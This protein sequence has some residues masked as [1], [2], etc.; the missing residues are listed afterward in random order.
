MSLLENMNLDDRPD[1]LA[2]DTRRRWDHTSAGALT[3][4]QRRLTELYRVL[5]RAPSVLLLD[6]PAAG[7]SATE[8]DEL[9]QVLR[10]LAD[11]GVAVL[12]IEHDLSL[13]WS[14]ADTVSV[15]E[16]GELLRTDTPQALAGDNSIDSLLGGVSSA[17]R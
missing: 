8:R 5:N 10:R 9:G 11:S 16:L 6:E 4:G 7:L 14:I 17:A 3:H 1:S 13:V 12:L 2:A 15:M